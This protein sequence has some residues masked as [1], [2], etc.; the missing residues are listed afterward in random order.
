MRTFISLL[1]FLL[2]W[3]PP[4]SSS[5]AGDDEKS[6]LLQFKS[7]VT[8]DP[9]GALVSWSP[10]LSPCRDFAGVSCNAAGNVEKILIHSA[11]LAGTLTPA[12]SRL[13][14]LQ[15]LSLFDN[16]FTGQI[17]ADFA[18]IGTLFKLNLSRNHLSGPVPDFLGDWPSLRLL[19]LGGNDFSGEIP[20]SLFQNCFR[21]R[22]V[23]FSCNRLCGSIPASISNC[24]NLAGLDFSHNNLT[25][26]LPPQIC[27]PPAINFIS[28]R[29]NSL[30]RT[31]TDKIPELGVSCSP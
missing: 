26:P 31:V 3:S 13:P 25:G 8:A 21:T 20:A 23:S 27:M 12:L 7:D 6:I 15:I 28:L 29:S 22:F 19:D 5:A 30:S 10:A 11:A 24:P 2:F 18:A 14:S 1:L 4:L 17:P 9:T 16:N